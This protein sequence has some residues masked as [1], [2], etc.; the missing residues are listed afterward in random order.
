MIFVTPQSGVRETIVVDAGNER[1]YRW[2]VESSTAEP[3]QIAASPKLKLPFINS[4]N[5]RAIGK[6][7][8]QARIANHNAKKLELRRAKERLDLL[9]PIVDASLAQVASQPVGSDEEYRLFRLARTREQLADLDAEWK[10]AKGDAKERKALADAIARLQDVEQR[11]ANRPLPGS[12]RPGREKPAR[13]EAA[14][15][16]LD[17][18]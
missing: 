11:L 8:A 16:P 3:Q 2:I 10:D 18:A 7:G 9:Q 1:E 6:A 12:R 5:A 14:G 13:S 15:G 17:V 4:S